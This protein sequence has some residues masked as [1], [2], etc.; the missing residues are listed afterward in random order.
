[1]SEFE[2]T[3]IVIYTWITVSWLALGLLIACL[4]HG[5]P[6]KHNVLKLTKWVCLYTVFPGFIF[7]A[8]IGK[9]P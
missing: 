9:A 3:S 2:Q 1:M 7:L 4:A 8:Y 5:M 6:T